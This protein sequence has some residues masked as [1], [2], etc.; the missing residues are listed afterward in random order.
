MPEEYIELPIPTFDLKEWNDNIYYNLKSSCF[1]ES[2]LTEWSD[3]HEHVD[4][5]VIKGQAGDG[6]FLRLGDGC[7]SFAFPIFDS[8]FGWNNKT[9]EIDVWMTLHPVLFRQNSSRTMFIGMFGLWVYAEGKEFLK[10]PSTQF[11]RE[12]NKEMEDGRHFFGFQARATKKYHDYVAQMM[13]DTGKG[14][15][16]L[17]VSKEMDYPSF[18]MGMMEIVSLRRTVAWREDRG[19]RFIYQSSKIE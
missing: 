11:G 2:D 17:L 14:M 15:R 1:G 6:V 3:Q 19:W 13:K 12:W 10:N 7:A 5:A 18:E 4:T 16:E 8:Y 9:G